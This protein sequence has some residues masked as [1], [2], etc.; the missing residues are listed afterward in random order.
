M[1]VAEQ[2]AFD[3]GASSSFPSRAVSPG[4]ASATF[5]FVVSV[6]TDNDKAC[7]GDPPWQRVCAG[8]GS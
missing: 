1:V 2:G 8:S 3:D 7:R 6:E 4:Y 5:R